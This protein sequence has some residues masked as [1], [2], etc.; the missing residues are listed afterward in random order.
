M[1]SAS[2]RATRRTRTTNSLSGEAAGV[3][4]GDRWR[5][6]CHVKVLSEGVAERAKARGLDALVYAPHF[7]RLEDVRERAER[8]SDEE[9]TVIPGRELL[10]GHWNAR[11][12]VLAVG[13]E[14]PVPDFITLR[15]A[16]AELQRQEATVLVPHPGFLNASLGGAE[17]GEYAD[18]IDGVEVYNA[19][20]LG[21]HERRA[22]RIAA[23]NNRPVYAS[24]Y[25]HTARAVGAGWTAFDRP[26]RSAAALAAA[27]ADDVHEV[28]RRDGARHRLQG[29]LE[30]GHLLW[31]GTWRKADR[32]LLQGT[33]PTHP[34]HVA[35]GGRFDDVRVY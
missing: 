9:L 20:F 27:L 21:H 4:D 34:G 18:V 11:R 2:A 5:V 28:G 8:H 33:E 14:D 25:A 32:I 13:L 7:T 16:M 30:L 12:H 3:S 26:V 10:T 1:R 29:T 6:D 23:E 17:V 24:S 19:K 35:Y 31:E 15:G 22:R